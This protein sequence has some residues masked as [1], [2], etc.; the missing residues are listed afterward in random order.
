MKTI[1]LSILSILFTSFIFISCND[2]DEMVDMPTENNI[3]E[4]A[5]MAGSFNTLIQ[6]ATQAGLANFLSTESQITVFAPTDA[7][8]S[9]L[10]DDLG[11]SSLT[12]IDNNTLASILTY[13]V[14]DGELYSN[15]LPSGSVST[16]NEK[17]PSESALSVLVNTDSGVKINNSTV[18]SADISASNGVIHVIDEVLIPPTVVDIAMT[19]EFNHLV[20]AV[21]KAELVETLSGTGPFTVFAPT[22]EAFEM[23]FAQLG[24]S[25]VDDVSKEDLQTILT[26]HVVPANVQSGDLSAGDVETVNS[27]SISISLDG[28]VKINGMANVVAADIQG[29]NGVVHVIDKVLLPASMQSNTIVDVAMSNADFSIL[30]EAL[31]KAELV[32]AVAD[33]DAML[34]VF[35]PTNTAFEQ[36]L[37]DLGAASLDDFS[38]EE[39]AQILLYH[40][41]G[42]K[43]MSS[44]ISAGY[45]PTLASYSNNNLSV[46]IG[47]ESSVSLNN[48]ATVTTPDLEADNGVIHV[49]DKVILPPTV[50]N[51]AIDNPTFS[52]LVEAV[53]KAELIET[54]SGDGAFT[55]FAPTNDAFE[56]LFNDLGVSG[57]AEL[58]KE[59]LVPILTYHVISGNVLA[60]DVTTGMVPTLNE[61]NSIDIVVDN[62]VTIDGTSNVI[63]TNVQGKNGVVHVID[64]VLIP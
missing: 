42:S 54:L 18:T 40:V 12:E 19:G 53:V 39:L 9:N 4:T 50:V 63:A 59:D 14:I 45:F 44:D 26:Y 47:T 23:L 43:V 34:T 28:G 20:S 6:A 46:L 61:G 30:V 51:I 60:A 21:V 41:M 33:P 29:I 36:L 7:A 5:Q 1:K 27:E 15:N 37:S 25:G 32:E 16:L 35:A 57:I 3:V 31:T 24:V 55:V 2:E 10:L 38:K 52:I 22:D 11:V 13:H 64:K 56:A 17:G 8:F 62:G 49:I 48:A 58:T